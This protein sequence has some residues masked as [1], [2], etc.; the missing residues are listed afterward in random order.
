M[1]D[2]NAF[3]IDVIENLREAISEV[4]DKDGRYYSL[5][6]RPYI[7]QDKKVDGVVLVII[8]IDAEKVAE[9]ILLNRENEFRALADNMSQLAWMTD[10]SGSIYRYNM[11]WYEYTGTTLED[12]KGWGWQKVHHPDHVERVVTKI[13]KSFEDGAIWEDTFP[14]RG[15]DGSYRWFLSRAQPIRDGN[16]HILRWIGTNTDIMESRTAEEQRSVLLNEL[17]HRVKNTLATVQSMASQTLRSSPSM[18]E[19]RSRLEAR[20]ISLSKAHDVL[21]RETWDSAPL[22]DIV[23]RAIAPYKGATLGRFKV[24]ATGDVRVAAQMALAFAMTLHELCTNAVKYGALSNNKGKVEIDW[25]TSNPK[26]SHSVLK[27]RWREIGGPPVTTP[28]T[29]GFGTKL[30][31]RNLASDLGATVKITFAKKGVTC[32]ITAA[33]EN[34]ILKLPKSAKRRDRQP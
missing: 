22:A 32:V 7:T 23:E 14:L 17:N 3:A 26:K 4:R 18:S 15:K 28:T 12:V 9:K 30:I 29:R 33:L 31:E 25:T 6:A 19:A 10:A 24:N 13:R 21:T 2:L 8:D 5:R 1:I 34:D 27:F 20:L 11:R 16:G